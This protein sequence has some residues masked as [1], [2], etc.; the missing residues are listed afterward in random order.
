MTALMFLV[1]TAS[2]VLQEH[3]FIAEASLMSVFIH[4]GAGEGGFA[5]FIV[6]GKS[7]LV[8][9]VWSGLPPS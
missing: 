3:Y 7:V 9:I 8:T 4:E 5:Q 1:S 6:Q 2:T